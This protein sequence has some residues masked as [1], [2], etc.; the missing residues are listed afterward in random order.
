MPH[1][2]ASQPAGNAVPSNSSSKT[3]LSAKSPG[4]ITSVFASG[5][6]PLKVVSVCVCAAAVAAPVQPAATHMATRA[7]INLR[8]KRV[9]FKTEFPPYSGIFNATFLP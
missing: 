6:P 4:G 1:G 2:A 8:M 5:V 3:G 9:W 7:K